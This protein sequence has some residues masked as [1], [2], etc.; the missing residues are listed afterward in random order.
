MRPPQEAERI[1]F[2][3]SSRVVIDEERLRTA[4]SA[5]FVPGAHWHDLMEAERVA[6]EV[7]AD[8]WGDVAAACDQALAEVHELYLGQAASVLEAKEDLRENGA[9]SWI[10]RAVRYQRAFNLAWD[11]LDEKGLLRELAE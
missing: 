5:R 8:E 3:V 11:V 6:G 2:D 4:V 9:D 7:V 10:A 1:I